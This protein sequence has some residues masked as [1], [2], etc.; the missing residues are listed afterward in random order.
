MM[1]PWTNLASV[2]YKRT[3]SRSDKGIPE[4]WPDTV[5]RVIGGNVRGRNVSVQET[6]RLEYLML[7]RKAAPAGRGL[8]YSGSPGHARLGG[9]ALSNCWGTTAHEWENFV[10]AQD[11]LMLGGGVG[12]SVEHRYVSKLPRVR[13]DVKIVHRLAKDAD[14]IIPDSREGWC[15]LTRRVLEAF[16]VTGRSFSFSAICVRPLGDP[17]NGFGGIAAG[18]GPL[19]TFV[20]KLC[21][22]LVSREGKSIRPIDAADIL[23]S[24]G[25]MVVSG[26]VRRSAIL[27]QG[28]GWDKEYL[29][30]KRWDL[31]DIPTQRAMANFS[32][33]CD[34]IED[35]HPLFW[36]TYESGEPFGIINRK[37][38]QAYGRMGERRR[39]SAVICNPCV[40]AG[41]EILTSLGYMAIDKLIGQTVSV[42]NGREFS[43]VQPQVTGT[44]QPL[45]RVTLSSGQELLCTPAHRFFI[46]DDY[47][48][49]PRFVQ[50]HELEKGTKLAKH[51]YPVLRM[52]EHVEAPVA[53]LQGFHAGDGMDG[54][55]HTTLYG[56][57]KIACATRMAGHLGAYSEA[58]DRSYFRY[59]VEMQPKTFVPFSWDLASKLEWFAGL[60]D[61]DGTELK[62][63]GSQIGSVE[64][65]FLLQIQKLLTTMS[66]S[67]KIAIMT[68]AGMRPLPDG[69]GG[70]KLYPCQTSWRLL[71]NAVQ[72]Q[73]LLK[74]G[75]SCSR[76]K[77]NKSPQRDASRF[78]TVLS[79]EDAGRAETVYC[80][81]EK[82]RGMGCFEGIV[83]GQCAEAVL[84]DGEPCNLQEIALPN[85][86][87]VEEFEEAARLMH[88]YGKRVTMEKYHHDKVQEVIDR[89]RR[90]GT[91]ITGCLEAPQFFNPEV[92]DRVYAAIQDENRTYSVELGIP[93]SIR[94]TVIKPSG[95]VSKLLDVRGEGLHPGFSRYMIQRIRFAA[96]DA[97]IPKL[98]AAG[99]HIEP[100][101]RFDG[102]LDRSTLVVDFYIETPAQLPCADEGW[103]TWKQLDTLLLAQRHWADQ[104][105]SV[106]IY[107][108]K[109][110]LP[111]LKTWLAENLQNLKTISFLCHN[112]HGFKQAP[113][114]AITKEQYETLSADLRPVDVDDDAGGGDLLG[115]ECEGGACP[116]R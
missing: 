36:K 115:T 82:R 97:L 20:E 100:V 1:K 43:D 45:V 44:D 35:L 69:K 13:K 25:E 18:P 9:V 52:G 78:V 32:V 29:R 98:R 112:D 71:I 12:M 68:P 94:T 86:D 83:T 31:G 7:N 57:A 75:L 6:S 24:I 38:I 106:T 73:D 67:S 48:S 107:Y 72:M 77:F 60:L 4:N 11:L 76:L 50:A 110:D 15:E 26:N 55:D 33:V 27:I 30:A 8:W 109:E 3:Y 74:L 88:R 5:A 41:T 14:F 39:D 42:W 70:S 22:L 81:K 51:A 56:T 2:V 104:A 28:D 64:R 63:G 111:R 37:N 108:R 54:Y 99:H 80:F 103:D 114:E 85:L 61:S 101:V 23:C 113:K 34:D 59:H 96:N 62:E 102:T 87:S 90:I 65:D 92:L 47:R 10:L 53:Y 49:V 58:Q 89:N 84:E 93:E 21:A 19:V 17:I 46:Q 91:G 16:F 66:V 105:V 116:I 40:P 95:T 79:V